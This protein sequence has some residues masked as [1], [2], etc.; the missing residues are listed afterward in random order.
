[1]RDESSETITVEAS[2]NT[3]EEYTGENVK[4]EALSYTGGWLLQVI[5]KKQTYHPVHTA[6]SF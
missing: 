5:K 6:S 3:E 1:M 2:E 4:E